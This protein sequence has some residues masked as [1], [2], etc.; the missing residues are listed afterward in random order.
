MK[1]IIAYSLLIAACGALAPQ[2]SAQKFAIK[3]Y[4]NIGLGKVMSVTNVQPGQTSKSIY[5][6]FG[7]DFGYTFWRK[8]AN[9]LEANLG[10]GYSMTKSTFS[11][12][13]F[14]YNYAAPSYADEDKNPY[15][16]Y[17]EIDYLKQRN[18]IGYFHVPVYLE[19]QYKP[20]KWLGIH[21][22]AGVTFGFLARKPSGMTTGSAY[23]YGVFPE[24]DDLL[25]DEDY[26]DDFGRRTVV[27]K[28]TCDA[29]GFAA[30]IM[31]GAGF[32]FYT[33]EPVSFELGVR[34]N[35]GLTQAFNGNNITPSADGSMVYTHETAPVY[36]T[37]AEG[38]Q[39]RSLSGFTSKSRLNVLSLHLGINVRF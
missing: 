12:G 14:K 27:G 37:V 7:I 22:E 6:A 4:D 32:E 39:V 33:Y 10:I 15:Q 3:G 34:Y 9:S 1:K 19:Y 18:T 25:I 16:R 31:C 38:T 36:Y 28:A 23:A 17:Y 30:N 29:S 26:L 20:L 2:A 13:N 11:I 24:Y 5:N 21:A 35:Y 8:G